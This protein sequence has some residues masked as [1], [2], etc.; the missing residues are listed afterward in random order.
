MIFVNYTP[1]FTKMDDAATAA[2]FLSTTDVLMNEWR[3]D[4]LSLYGLNIGI[5]GAMVTNTEPVKGFKGTI[6][7]FKNIFSIGYLLVKF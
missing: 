4:I 7:G 1:R 3:D 2:D 5:R 6:L